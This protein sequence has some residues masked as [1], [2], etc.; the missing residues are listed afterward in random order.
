MLIVSRFK[1]TVRTYKEW[2]SRWHCL[3]VP[4]WIK[5]AEH[6][7]KGDFAA[8]EALY[9]AGLVSHP[10]SPA[11]F[12]ALLDLS[13][14]LFRLRKFEEAENFMR[15]ATIVAPHEREA[16]VRLARLQLWL[17]YASEAVWTMRVCVQR[18]SVDP[19]LAALFITAVVESGGNAATV[20]EARELLAGLHCDGGFP[21]LEVARARL[22]LLENESVVSRDN[23]SKL[24]SIDRGPFEAVVA[25]AE[26]LL[27]EGKIA[28]ARHHLHRSL[29]VA[30]EHPKVLRLLAQSYLSPG[31]FFE[32]EYGVQIALKACQATAWRGV[33]E[34]LTLAQAYIA[35][36]DNS[37]ALL[38]AT[39]A[40]DVAARLIGAYP[41]VAR[42]EQI[43]QAN[44]SGSQL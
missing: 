1:R 22:A 27:K 7:Q 15:Q 38:A 10:Q 36:H 34:L 16:Y 37:A 23:L 4:A 17:G 32:P 18:V 12:N 2:L 24:A 35:S 19:E 40:K 21:K 29:V 13:H 20:I 6:Y 14:C 42:I 3:P 25:F 39:R 26:V 41:E 33:H 11:K 30:P 28:Y 5:A 44:D 31:I 43:L 8:A 9:K